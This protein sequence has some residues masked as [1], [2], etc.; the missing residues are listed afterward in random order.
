[1]CN[2]SGGRGGD[3]SVFCNI[4]SGTTTRRSYTASSAGKTTYPVTP[5]TRKTSFPLLS[6]KI[7]SQSTTKAAKKSTQD[8]PKEMI[9]KYT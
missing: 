1:M 8:D 5:S 9:C 4:P 6:T 7:P 2:F 3:I